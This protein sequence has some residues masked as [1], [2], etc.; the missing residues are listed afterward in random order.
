MEK[1]HVCHILLSLPRK[2]SPISGSYFADWLTAQNQSSELIAGCVHVAPLRIRITR[3]GIFPRLNIKGRLIKDAT[4]RIERKKIH[5]ILSTHSIDR[6]C[7]NRWNRAM[8]RAFDKYVK[9]YGVPNITHCH[10]GRGAG[11]VGREIWMKH[12][13]P[14][15][16]SEH[17]PV[18][19]KGSLN[20]N[21]KLRLQR[22]YSDSSAVCPVSSGMIP[23]IKGI[24]G[25]TT[26]C[27]IEVLP[28]AFSNE[29]QNRS[30]T[31]AID[32]G[33]MKGLSQY[34]AMVGR[35]DENKSQETGLHAFKA[36]IERGYSGEL[37]IA[38]TGNRREDLK[39]LAESLGLGDRIHFLG[40]ISKQQVATLLYESD[41]M[42][43]TSR[44]ES[45]GLPVIESLAVGC[46]VVSTRCGGPEEISAE[47]NKGIELVDV[48]D[49]N[50]MAEASFRL[51]AAYPRFHPQRVKCARDDL[52]ETCLKLY[53]NSAFAERTIAIYSIAT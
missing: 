41:V 43:L 36:M 29:F 35:L 13:I 48:G 49:A 34:V 22:V 47:M 52:R 15:V 50:A 6:R 27:R 7:S 4:Q 37:R 40:F 28:N 30:K 11:E 38:G 12:K 46:P 16:V 14:Y 3:R 9:V 39:A 2:E 10:S 24:V 33:Q 45:F 31:S 25:Q 8:L 44:H 19:L 17:N 23:T 5:H 20:T 21:E 51:L 18:Y 53:G 1:V 32:L 42:L 26:D